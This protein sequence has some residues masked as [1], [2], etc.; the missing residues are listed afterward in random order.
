MVWA[1]LFGLVVFAEFPDLWSWIGAA[2][3]LVATTY[4]AQR[5]RADRRGA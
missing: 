3:I 4:I 5:E 2:L 1:T